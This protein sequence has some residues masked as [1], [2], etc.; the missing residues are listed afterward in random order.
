MPPTGQWWNGSGRCYSSPQPELLLALVY[1]ILPPTTAVF[2]YAIRLRKLSVRLP[3]FRWCSKGSKFVTTNP[4]MSGRVSLIT[5]CSAYASTDNS[6]IVQIE[7][8]LL[9]SVF[10]T[11]GGCVPCLLLHASTVLVLKH[12]AYFPEDSGSVRFT[13]AISVDRC[14]EIRNTLSVA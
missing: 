14:T 7:T 2:D 4:S 5:A 11:R 9:L 3:V 13:M 1:H 12:I 10:F 8:K 6:K